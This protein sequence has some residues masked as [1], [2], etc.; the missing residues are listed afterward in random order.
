MTTVVRA[1]EIMKEFRTGKVVVHALRGVSLEIEA[2]EML[3]IVG[4]SGSGKSTLLG[5]LGGLDTPTSGRAEVGS[6]DITDMNESQ[7][8]D[9]RSTKIGF[10]FQ[11]FNLIPTLTALEN[12]ALPAQFARS[13][14]N[15][16]PMRRARE[17]LTTVGL[18]DRLKHRPAELSG[19]EQQRVAL[20]RA[21]VNQPAL[22]LADEPTGNLDSATGEEVL[23]LLRRLCDESG[24]TVIMVTHDP[25][26]ATYADRVAFLQDG[27]IVE[28]ARL[29]R[30][31]DARMILARLAEPIL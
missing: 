10:V 16:K 8:A 12:V 19:G 14:S 9:V 2:G 21:M 22:I 4:P 17:L 27:R 31:R 25:R 11:T 30:G 20:A 23:R 29:E 18:G 13:R 15:V 24:Q 5:L 7:L 3:A 1:T 6:L 28:E 26:V